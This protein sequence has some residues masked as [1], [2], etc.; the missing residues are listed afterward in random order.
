MAHYLAGRET[1]ARRDLRSAMRFRPIAVGARSYGPL[2]IDNWHRHRA[3]QQRLETRARQDT[4][5]VTGW[6]AAGA[7]AY[8][9]L[10]DADPRSAS[11]GVAVPAFDKA[12][13]ID[14]TDIDG[15]MMRGTAL[16]GQHF[17]TYAERAIADLSEVIR[18][19]PGHAE[20]Y[21]RRSMVHATDS[22][23]LGLAV[24]DCERALALIPGDPM[25]EAMLG[26]FKRSQVAVLA[27][28]RREAELRA[29]RAAAQESAREQAAAAL[30]AWLAAVAISGTPPSLTYEERQA[31]HTRMMNDWLQDLATRRDR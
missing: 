16:S 12:L 19:H 31:E 3:L 10:D 18:L 13:S 29:E 23:S 8:R 15:L 5:D 22:S 17:T 11:I 4:S 26:R 21:L 27:R 6:L 25:L 30:L 1:E 20:A 28:Q 7:I 9:S 24:A 2:R 14:P